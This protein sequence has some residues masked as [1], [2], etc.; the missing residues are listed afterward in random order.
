MYAG[1]LGAAVQQYLLVS[2]TV[3]QEFANRCQDAVHKFLQP[4]SRFGQP[5]LVAE[6]QQA[7][8]ANRLYQFFLH[9][10]FPLRLQN[11]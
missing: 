4:P 11:T 6:M 7:V 8:S 9:S 3:I 5:D 10:A 1:S 2:G